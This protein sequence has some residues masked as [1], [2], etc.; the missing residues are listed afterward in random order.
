MAEH[1]PEELHGAALPTAA[2]HAGD[3]IPEALVGVGDAKP[4]AREAARLEREQE[5]GPERLGLG[6]ADVQ[7]ED[8]ADAALVDGVGSPAPSA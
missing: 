1:V 2:E 3:R 8:F 7:A 5:L 6:F 4:H